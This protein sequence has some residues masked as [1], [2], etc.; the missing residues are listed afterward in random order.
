MELELQ[1]RLTLSDPARQ[2]GSSRHESGLMHGIQH[3]ADGSQMGGLSTSGVQI[4]D[5]HGMHAAATVPYT[6]YIDQPAAR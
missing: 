4:L 6:S 1:D 5:P 3:I 2:T